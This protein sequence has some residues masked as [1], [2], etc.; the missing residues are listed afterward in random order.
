MRGLGSPQALPSW[1]TLVPSPPFQA[2]GASYCLSTGPG[3]VVSTH[4]GQAGQPR[5]HPLG[6]LGSGLELSS[7][8]W[9]QA[10]E[11]GPRGPRAG[12]A[13]FALFLE[14]RPRAKGSSGGQESSTRSLG[15]Y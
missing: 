2:Q 9:S 12:L 11:Q 7:G 5:L 3:Q 13:S 8:E 15:T 4:P 6:C 1:P 14:A 10:V